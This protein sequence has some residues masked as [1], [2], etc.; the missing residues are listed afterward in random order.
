MDSI[1]WD[2]VEGQT[3]TKLSLTRL[4]AT[5]KSWGDLPLCAN[6]SSPTTGSR[7]P[8]FKQGMCYAVVPN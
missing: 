6:D 1:V 4:L 2:D 7:D 3:K 5:A 8:F